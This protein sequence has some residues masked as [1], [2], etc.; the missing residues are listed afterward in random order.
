M[1]TFDGRLRPCWSGP[2]LRHL[3]LAA[4]ATRSWPS[5]QGEEASA[6]AMSADAIIE[7]HPATGLYRA[8]RD[9][10]KGYGDR[11]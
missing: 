3:L 11:L 7:F 9:G 8:M 2:W 10:E 6:P 5:C 1:R 4:T